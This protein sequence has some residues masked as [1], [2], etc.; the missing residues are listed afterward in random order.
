MPRAQ[1]IGEDVK[2]EVVKRLVAHAKERWPRAVMLISWRGRF[3]GMSA[4]PLRTGKR[5]SFAGLGIQEP[6]SPGISV[7]SSILRRNMRPVS[8]RLETLLEHPK[9]ALIVLD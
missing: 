2:A 5:S 8:Y 3:G 4:R 6:S 7:S 1:S 9:T